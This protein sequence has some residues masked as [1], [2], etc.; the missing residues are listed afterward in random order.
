MRRFG[1]EFFKEGDP[2]R[3]GQAGGDFGHHVADRLAAFHFC[4]VDLV[5]KTD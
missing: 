5:M 2:V 3:I 4:I 1:D